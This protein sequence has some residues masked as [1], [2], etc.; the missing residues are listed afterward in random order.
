[1][2]DGDDW[3]SLSALFAAYEDF[4]LSGSGTL[5]SAEPRLEL[6]TWLRDRG[7]PLLEID[8]VAW[9]GHATLADFKTP[10]RLAA[11]QLAW[12]A[13]A[14]EF[15]H[16]SGLVTGGRLVWGL[17]HVTGVHPEGV[18]LG[19]LGLAAGGHL[20]LLAELRGGHLY[21]GVRRTPSAFRNFPNGTIDQQ[22]TF[23]P[24]N[25]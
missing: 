3:R 23:H 21:L 8:T 9:R 1:M 6:A 25:L 13:C 10:G 19:G 5:R 17:E 15:D 11:G 16:D 14:F 2:L 4:V 18:S 12:R 20:W 22:D 7:T 24:L